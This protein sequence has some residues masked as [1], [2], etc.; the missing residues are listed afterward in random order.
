MGHWCIDSRPGGQRPSIIRALSRG[1]L[2]F[3]PFLRKSFMNKQRVL[4]WMSAGAIALSLLSPLSVHAQ[5]ETSAALSLM[6]VASVV[7]AASAAGGAVGEQTR[8]EDR[9]LVGGVAERGEG[10]CGHELI[11]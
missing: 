7:G 3:P 1:F 6:P 9:A 5:S 4:A 2:F 8:E 10:R 11:G